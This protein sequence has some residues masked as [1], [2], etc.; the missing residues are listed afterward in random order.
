MAGRT[1]STRVAIVERPGAE[2]AFTEVE[3]DGPRADEVLVRIV[4]TG[5][6]HTDIS[7]RDTLPAEM[8]PRVFGHEGAGVVEEVGAD[9][10]GIEVGDHVVLSLASCGSCARCAAGEVGYC[11]QTLVLNYMGMRMDGSTTYTRDGAPVFASFLGQSSLSELALVHASSCVVVD[12]A[13][14][15]TRVAPYGCGFQTG[16]GAVLNVLQPDD[17]DTVVV[18]GVGAVGLAAVAAARS[19]GARTFAVDLAPS[20]LAEAERLGAVPVNPADLDGG[21][22]VDYLKELTGGGSTGAIET[23]AVPAVIADA[24]KALGVRGRLVVLGLDM[25]HPEF[26]LDAVD[27]LQSGKEVRSSVEGDSDP[28]TMVPRLLGLAAEGRFDVD[29]LLATYPF[30]EINAAI[31]DV[32]AG[33]VVKPVLVW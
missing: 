19:V 2:F 26:T 25:A 24:A 17:Q 18:Y 22:L 21:T 13:L 10:T 30:A 20:R 14:D 12:P 23:T 9:V 16:A 32:L 6:C 1:R 28:A 4:A 31:D 15:L 33:K 29:P 5:L 3:I 7:L 27:L 8:F 11:D